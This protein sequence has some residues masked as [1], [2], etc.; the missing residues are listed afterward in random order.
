MKRVLTALVLIPVVL[1]LVFWVPLWLFILAVAALV[2][3]CLREYLNIAD[4]AGTKPFRWIT[5]V[6]GVLPFLLSLGSMSNGHGFSHR[7]LFS[8]NLGL[9]TPLLVIVFGI[10]LVFRKDLRGGLASVAASICGVLYVSFSLSFL[11]GLR[12]DF[13][14]TLLIFL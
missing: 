10:P 2:V 7:L 1:L 14:I 6:I 4:A 11:V 12:S 5:Y 3:L 8:M 13:E 9:F